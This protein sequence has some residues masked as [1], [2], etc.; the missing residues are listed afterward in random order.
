MRYICLI[1]W[2][3]IFAASC[4]EKTQKVDYY[5]YRHLDTGKVNQLFKGEKF[6]LYNSRTDGL[7]Y[8]NSLQFDIDTTFIKQVDSYVEQSPADCD[9]CT[10]YTTNIYQAFREGTTTIRAFRKEFADTSLSSEQLDSLLKKTSPENLE[11]LKDSLKF[12]QVLVLKLDVE[13]KSKP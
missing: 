4:K 2:G 3:L 12:R 13:I 6:A 5:A 1:I 11:K 7:E 9:G 10:S 8:D